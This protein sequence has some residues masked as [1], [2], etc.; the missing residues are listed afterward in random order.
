MTSLIFYSF[1]VLRTTSCFIILIGS[2]TTCL[3]FLTKMTSKTMLD[4]WS[5]NTNTIKVYSRNV[6]LTK[7][8]VYASRKL[9]LVPKKAY[10]FNKSK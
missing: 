1:R 3:K 5:V 8:V 10:H 9:L 4:N 7:N 2:F 6:K